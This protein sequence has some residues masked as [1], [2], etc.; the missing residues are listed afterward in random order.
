ML[1]T[2]L[3]AQRS[4]APLAAAPWSRSDVARTP[5]ATSVISGSVPDP[6]LSSAT[7]GWNGL[8]VELHSFEA[9]DA[10][11]QQPDHVI[12]VHIGGSTTLHQTRDGR[13]R[14]RNV[15]VGDIAITPKGSPVGWRQGSHTLVI[16]LRLAPEYVCNVA[17]GECAVDPGRFEIKGVFGTRDQAVEQLGRQLLAGLELEGADSHLYADTLAFK[18]TIHLLRHY[19]TATVTEWPRT[20]LSPY[21]LR[22]AIGFIDDNLGHSLTLSAIAEAV[23]LSPGHFAHAFREA[24]GVSPH[25]YVIERRVERAKVLLRQSQLP[26]TE[27]ADRIGCSSNSHFSV[28]FH[29][30]TGLTPSQFRALDARRA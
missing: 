7:R 30:V 16:L 25:R 2:R 8:T 23:S 1:A 17:G 10:V 27:I 4:A 24:T 19:T 3:A 14:T 29:R 13:T 15:S 26:I 22:R 5:A 9:T 18:L 21:K 6:L 11:V 28:L 12:A 20:R